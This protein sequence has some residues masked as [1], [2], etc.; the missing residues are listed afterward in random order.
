[1]QA[2]IE[3][4]KAALRDQY[5]DRF[6]EAGYPATVEIGHDLT[7][8]RVTFGGDQARH[9]LPLVEGFERPAIPP[10]PFT[11]DPEVVAYNQRLRDLIVQRL[12]EYVLTYVHENGSIGINETTFEFEDLRV[13]PS[14]RTV[15]RLVLAR[16]VRACFDGH[17]KFTLQARRD[18]VDVTPEQLDKFLR[19]ILDTCKV[20][21]AGSQLQFG[22][23]AYQEDQP[24]SRPVVEDT[25][26]GSF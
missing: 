23:Q 5:E 12:A 18:H 3:E 10:V 11:D 9:I 7:L 19:K 26:S 21:L 13:S 24:T 6:R 17:K 8:Q 1:M 14:E 20:K 16:G 25:S 4:Q 22:R 15:A 2:S